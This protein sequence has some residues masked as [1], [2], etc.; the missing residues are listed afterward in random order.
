MMSV[1]LRSV[2]QRSVE[3][4][5]VELRSV[6]LS[7]VEARSVEL[8]SVEAN[9]A[10]PSR[11]EPDKARRAGAGRAGPSWLARANAV[12]P[13]TGHLLVLCCVTHASRRRWAPSCAR[14]ELGINELNT[15]T[16]VVFGSTRGRTLPPPGRCARRPRIN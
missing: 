5:S 14:N 6:E 15:N 7:S 1:E 9:R 2:E 10:E 12:I 13:T 8:R 3:Q 16:K 4:R 11:A